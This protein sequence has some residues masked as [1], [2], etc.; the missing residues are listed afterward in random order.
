M[1][2]IRFDNRKKYKSDSVRPSVRLIVF[3]DSGSKSIEYR[4]SRNIENY[5]EG[6]ST[7]TRWRILQSASDLLYLLCEKRQKISE[8]RT[9]FVGIIL[10]TPRDVFVSTLLLM[11]DILSSS[12]IVI[13]RKFAISLVVIACFQFFVAQVR[14]KSK[15]LQISIF[16]SK[17]GRYV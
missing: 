10:S 3:C 15:H 9:I 14:I 2:E 7:C 4:D 8:N 17:Q 16:M 11:H 12:E 13:I 6:V 1:R 5:W